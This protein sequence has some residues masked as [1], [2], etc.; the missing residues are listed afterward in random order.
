MEYIEY[1][2]AHE[3]LAR[4]SDGMSF[5]IEDRT[6]IIYLAWYLVVSSKGSKYGIFDGG[7]DEK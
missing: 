6:L 4:L 1:G 7:I 2:T 5:G 3:K